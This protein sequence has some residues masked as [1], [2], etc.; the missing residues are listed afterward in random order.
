MPIGFLPFCASRRVSGYLPVFR[1]FRVRRQ[2]SE[3]GFG[4][5]VALAPSV[6]QLVRGFRGERID[7]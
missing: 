6:A 7:V 5:I 4:R 1:K 2:Q 3:R